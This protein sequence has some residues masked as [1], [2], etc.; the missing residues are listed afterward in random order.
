MIP[1]SINRNGNMFTNKSFAC[2]LCEKAFTTSG[3]LNRHMQHHTGHY[4]H[5]CN[6][7]GKGFNER[8]LY[9]HHMRAHEGIT[10]RC[11]M[12]GRCFMLKASMEKH[13]LSHMWDTSVASLFHKRSGKTRACEVF[14]V[15]NC[16]F[17]TFFMF[18]FFCAYN[19]TVYNLNWPILNIIYLKLSS[20][21]DIH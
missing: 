18:F 7:C 5:R 20:L 4:R 6:Q 15:E 3:N 11:K 9:D 16:Y 17:R 1:G 8:Q 12:C 2:N 13:M 14:C 19:S 21:F 10:F